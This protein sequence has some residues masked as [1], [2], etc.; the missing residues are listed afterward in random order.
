[1]KLTKSAL[2]EEKFVS[3][4]PPF[5]SSS[6]DDDSDSGCRCPGLRGDGVAAGEVIGV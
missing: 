3:C 1:M 2:E 6:D 4:F 5:T